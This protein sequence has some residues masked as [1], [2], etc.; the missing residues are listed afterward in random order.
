MLWKFNK[1]ASTVNPVHVQDVAQA[2][3]N[4][5]SLPHLDGQTLS[6]PGPISFSH[7]EL[8][9]LV[10][11]FTFRPVSTAPELPKRL[12][13]FL[14]RLAQ[15]VW[16]PV[17]SPDEVERRF[18]SEPGGEELSGGDWDKVGVEPAEIEDVAIAVLRRY[19]SG[20]VFLAQSRRSLLMPAPKTQLY[21]ARRAAICTQAHFGMPYVPSKHIDLILTY[22]QHYHIAE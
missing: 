19:R 13:L 8:E 4:L 20:C 21:T 10:S 1:G 5:T 16:W 7:K 9:Q 14:S 22:V 3:A 17:L 11:L 12:A 2:L 6:F 15:R 18:V